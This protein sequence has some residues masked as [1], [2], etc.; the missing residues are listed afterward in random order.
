[1]QLKEKSK[2]KCWA[3]RALLRS[4]MGRACG[5]FFVNFK[6]E[7]VFKT[8]KDTAMGPWVGNAFPA[9]FRMRW[10]QTNFEIGIMRCPFCSF[11]CIASFISFLSPMLSLLLLLPHEVYEHFLHFPS[12]HSTFN[13]FTW[14]VCFMI[15]LGRIF[16]R[17]KTLRRTPFP[18]ACGAGAGRD[19]GF[20]WNVYFV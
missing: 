7:N 14:N 11:R 5:W 17:A 1:M 18:F 6:R 13:N 8:N 2:R 4:E 12:V 16:A 19:R 20:T 10:K 15:K 3:T 9:S